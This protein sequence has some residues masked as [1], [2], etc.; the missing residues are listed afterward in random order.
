MQYRSPAN[1][2]LDENN[3]DRMQDDFDNFEIP[4]TTSASLYLHRLADEAITAKLGRLL[5]V[6]AQEQA[7][8]LGISMDDRMA[9]LLTL[10][11]MRSLIPEQIL[12][13]Y[14]DSPFYI[15]H[16]DLHNRNIIIQGEPI[17]DQPDLTTEEFWQLSK[18]PKGK[19]SVSQECIQDI[20]IAG[21]VDWDA[22][23]P[24]PLQLAAIYPK[25][26][27]TLP[28]AQFPDLP[29]NYE[30]PDL[31]EEKRIFLQLFKKKEKVA[32]GY[33]VASDLL[34][35]GSWERDFFTESFRNG[36]IRVKWLEWWKNRAGQSQSLISDIPGSPLDLETY[37]KMRLGLAQYLQKQAHRD[38]VD[39]QSGWDL[40]ARTFLKLDGLEAEAVE[41]CLIKGFL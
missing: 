9:D 3:K 15:N 21:I 30:R 7:E 2:H 33:T 35:H 31:E 19:D 12:G 24:L 32:T 36:G 8:S 28:G 40:V 25:F 10:C 14:N 5:A 37:S 26:L 34:E 39:R 22:A 1:V 20:K 18:E 11:L 6:D 4:P 17:H 41:N 27:E 13:K 23:H 29:K 38:N 16:P